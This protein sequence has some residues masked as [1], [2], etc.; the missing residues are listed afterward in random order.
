MISIDDT[1]WIEH[2]NNF[3]NVSLPQA[4]GGRAIAHE[5]LQRSFHDPACIGFSRMH[6]SRQENVRASSELTD[7]LI[8]TG[9]WH[10][11]YGHQ[12]A[13]VPRQG[14][15]QHIFSKVDLLRIV[16]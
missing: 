9:L 12:R 3:K 2:G 15:T 16:R 1:V 5:V 11:C 6:P 4:L 7:M 14:L 8:V 10:C 13:A